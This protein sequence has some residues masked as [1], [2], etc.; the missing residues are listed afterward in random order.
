MPEAVPASG[1][2]NTFHQ[3]INIP[4]GD[5]GGLLPH[6][7]GDPLNGFVDPPLLSKLWHNKYC[8]TMIHTQR[9]QRLPTPQLTTTIYH[10][11]VEQ[12][13]L[14]TWSPAYNWVW[15]F[16]QYKIKLNL[17]SLIYKNVF[18]FFIHIFQIRAQSEQIN[19]NSCWSI[20]CIIYSCQY[21][22]KI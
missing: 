14:G 22:T 10:T 15:T 13:M 2:I 21:T 7:N 17:F 5:V 3:S 11:L 20:G 4:L 18:A 6:I 12:C 9:C 8:C 16:I 19:F 1:H